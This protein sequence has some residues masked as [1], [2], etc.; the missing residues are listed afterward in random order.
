MA[1]AKP[2]EISV[3]FYGTGIFISLKFTKLNIQKETHKRR[4]QQGQKTTGD[5]IKTDKYKR[6][7][8]Y[9]T[10]TKKENSEP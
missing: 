10:I 5:N 1:V 2:L 7:T 6:K 8:A 3:V 9:E 4:S